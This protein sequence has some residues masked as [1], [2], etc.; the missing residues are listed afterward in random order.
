MDGVQG[1]KLPRN[2][3]LKFI[4]IL[5]FRDNKSQEKSSALSQ[6]GVHPL[7]GYAGG[8]SRRSIQWE[9]LES[10]RYLFLLSWH[11]IFYIYFRIYFFVYLIFHAL[12]GPGTG[13]ADAAVR[14]SPRL[15]PPPKAPV[16]AAPVQKP[17]VLNLELEGILLH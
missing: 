13:K 4:F 10:C 3:H 15:T 17:K 16:R 7:Q 1:T 9:A 8:R 6:E 11:G 2:R 12:G 5:I 14:R